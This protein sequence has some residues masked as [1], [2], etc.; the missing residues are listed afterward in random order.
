[1]KSAPRNAILFLAIF[2]ICQSLKAQTP[3]VAQILRDVEAKYTSLQSYS[4]TGEAVSGIQM[5]ESSSPLSSGQSQDFRTTFTI[6]LA[7]PEMYRVAWE[8]SNSVMA[9]RG[10]VWA[11]GESR[12]V[13]SPGINAQPKDTETALAMATGVSFGAAHTIPSLFFNLAGGKTIQD[14]AGAVL[15][16]GETIDGDDCYVVKAHAEGQ[17]RTLWISKSSKLIRQ[18]MTVMTPKSSANG[19]E[20]SDAD[21]KQVLES[22]GQKATDESIRNLRNQMA[23]AQQLAKSLKS[24]YILERQRDI[25]TNDP[26]SAADFR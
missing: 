23:N 3:D 14:A 20:L 8:Q 11:D 17:D 1:M 5:D 22:I 13:V 6:K 24:G 16:V 18:V 12:H 19:A 4:A 9:M 15:G 26:M 7:R 21:V 25:K 2:G 10:A